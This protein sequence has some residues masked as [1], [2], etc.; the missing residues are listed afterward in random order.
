VTTASIV[1]ALQAVRQG[2]ALA[3]AYVESPPLR[4]PIRQGAAAIRHLTG[5]DALPH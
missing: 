2:H 4:S 5:S 3:I 1:V